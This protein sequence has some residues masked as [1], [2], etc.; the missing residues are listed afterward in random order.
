VGVGVCLALER[1]Q[2]TT[3]HANARKL[4]KLSQVWGGCASAGLIINALQL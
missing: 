3:L 4:R 1:A 2:G